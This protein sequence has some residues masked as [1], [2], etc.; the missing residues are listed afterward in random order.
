MGYKKLVLLE[1]S[2]LVGWLVGQPKNVP[3]LFQPNIKVGSRKMAGGSGTSRGPAVGVGPVSH[4][5][6]RS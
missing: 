4:V 6:G 1:L 3:N 5:H 2:K